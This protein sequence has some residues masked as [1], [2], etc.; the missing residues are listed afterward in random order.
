MKANIS[1]S[2]LRQLLLSFIC[3]LLVYWPTRP[4]D[5]AGFVC[6]SPARAYVMIFHAPLLM[7]LS[8]TVNNRKPDWLFLDIFHG[9]INKTMIYI[10]FNAHTAEGIGA[11]VT[12]LKMYAWLPEFDPS[13]DLKWWICLHASPTERKM[14]IAYNY[15]LSLLIRS[16][17]TFCKFLK[18]FYK[19]FLNGLLGPVMKMQ[20]PYK[21]TSWSVRPMRINSL[22]RWFHD[23]GKKE[24]G[25]R[26]GKKKWMK[27]LGTVVY[28]IHYGL[29]IEQDYL[30]NDRVLPLSLSIG[31]Y[32]KRRPIPTPLVLANLFPPL[33]LC[34]LQK[35]FKLHIFL[36]IHP[37]MNLFISLSQYFIWFLSNCRATPFAL[38][39]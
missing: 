27:R 22:H 7:I 32:V 16:F 33:L 14:S 8:T 15:P 34:L 26:K 11:V 37:I 39:I 6:S 36:G 35:F 4:T 23:D 9:I 31:L 5:D 2:A 29:T 10:G 20:S 21:R 30:D 12:A 17:A 19:N 13:W 28:I 25:I 24:L 18:A 1:F 3:V 38:Y